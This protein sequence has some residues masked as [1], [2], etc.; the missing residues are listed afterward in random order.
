MGDHGTISRRDRG[1]LACG[2]TGTGMFAN[3]SL[4]QM[5]QYHISSPSHDSG[6]LSIPD[7]RPLAGVLVAECLGHFKTNPVSASVLRE[8][9]ALVV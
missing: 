9:G 5:V 8:D 6:L 3:C 2:A 7:G 1:P 4:D